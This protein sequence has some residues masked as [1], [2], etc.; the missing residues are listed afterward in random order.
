MRSSLL[1]S[2][3][4]L[5]ACASDVETRVEYWG[6]MKVVLRDG[7][8][9]GRVSRAEIIGPNTVAVGALEGLSAEITV[10]DG[11]THLAEVTEGTTGRRLNIRGPKA[12]EQAT[13]LVAAQVASWTEHTLPQVSTLGELESAIRDIAKAQGIEVSRPFPFKVNGIASHLHVHVLNPSCPIANPDGP[14]PWT[15]DAANENVVLVGF[16]ASNAAGVLTHHGQSSHIHAVIRTYD[17]SGHLDRIGLTKGARL[18]LP[19]K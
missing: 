5:T 3:L 11:V 1:L 12:G 13:L 19:G 17:V 15:F 10:V 8:T 7:Q 14:S 2:L 18:F 6:A 9:Q 4:L 16:H